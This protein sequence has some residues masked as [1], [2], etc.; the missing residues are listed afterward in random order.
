MSASNRRSATRE[1]TEI[2][3]VDQRRELTE[4]RDSPACCSGPKVPP[5]SPV[6]ELVSLVIRDGRE[7]LL[8]ACAEL[9]V[10]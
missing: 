10:R 1:P 8:A 6:D 5:T 4:T 9:I 7:K 3:S 2:R